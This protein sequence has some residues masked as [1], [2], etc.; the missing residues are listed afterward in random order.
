M[1][2]N[3]PP[4]PISPNP[5]NHFGLDLTKDSDR[6]LFVQKDDEW[7]EAFPDD[8][9]GEKYNQKYQEM[10]QNCN[11]AISEQ[12]ESDENYFNL[13]GRTP[14]KVISKETI[15]KGEEVENEK[16]SYARFYWPNSLR[17]RFRR[18]CME[19]QMEMSYVTRQLV[20]KFINGEIT[21]EKKIENDKIK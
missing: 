13:R 10:L 21:I 19:A 15:L 20:E 6:I 8:P 11:V 9:D 3:Y 5:K 12:V 14:T 18:K 17:N 7:Q 4:L 16:H 1:Q 2:L